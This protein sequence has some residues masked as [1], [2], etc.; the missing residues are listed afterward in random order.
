MKFFTKLNDIYT[1][2]NIIDKF[3][4]KVVRTIKLDDNI[5]PEIKLNEVKDYYREENENIKNMLNLKNIIYYNDKVLKSIDYGDLTYNNSLICD[6]GKIHEWEKEKKKLNYD[7]KDVIC[8]KCGKKLSEIFNKKNYENKLFNNYIYQKT[9]NIGLKYCPSGTPHLYKFKGNK[10]VCE[11]CGYIKG[12]KIKDDNIKKIQDSFYKYIIVKNNYDI[13]KLKTKNIFNDLKNKYIKDIKTNPFDLL[14]KYLL[15]KIGSKIN[16]DNDEYYINNNVYIFDHNNIG[17]NLKEN[18]EILE[19]KI[20]FVKNHSFYKEDVYYYITF[21]KIEVYYSYTTNKLLGYKEQ[22]KNYVNLQSQN[23]YYAKIKYSLMTKLKYIFF[24]KFFTT[25]NEKENIYDIIYEAFIT[26]FK[27]INEL[28]TFIFM[29]NNKKKFVEKEIKTIDKEM[30]DLINNEN[31]QNEI[32]YEKFEIEKYYSN[33]YNIDEKDV[34]YDWN[35]ILYSIMDNIDLDDKITPLNINV[36]VDNFNILN[37]F[38]FFNYLCYY[39]I[40]EII[41]LDKKYNI[42]TF[43]LDYINNF[44]SNNSIQPY[45]NITDYITFLGKIHCTNDKELTD[46]MNLDEEEIEKAKQQMESIVEG[47]DNGK[48]E[49][50]DGYNLYQDGDDDSDDDNLD[51][52]INGLNRE[53]GYFDLRHIIV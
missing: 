31:K 14:S 41:N 47:T 29:I 4:E 2:K 25:I 27:F 15:E 28:L 26:S 6:D 37:Q 19:D 10:E 36:I 22:N 3:K 50:N 23:N 43:I 8:V 32:T 7:K 16:I 39:I 24:K 11:L 42:I 9:S 38:N 48:D 33:N 51:G 40:N 17:Y 44:F 1:N 46:I 45:L 53:P 49:E 18:L 35:N 13:T 21:N 52:D 34:F 30:E 20:K 5:K 12:E